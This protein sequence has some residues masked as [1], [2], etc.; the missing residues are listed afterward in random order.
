MKDDNQTPSSVGTFKSVSNAIDSCSSGGDARLMQQSKS[1]NAGCWLYDRCSH[2]DC[3]GFCLRRFKLSRLYDEAMVSD[4]QR[5]RIDL[6]V[7]RDLSDLDNFKYLST[8]EKNILGFVSHGGSLY[9]SSPI[10]GNGKTSWA[11]RLLQSY[12]DHIWPKSDLSCHGLFVHVPRLLIELKENISNPSDYARHVKENVI[13]ADLVVWDEIGTKGLTQFEHENI[14]NFVNAR[15]NAGKANIYTSN[16]SNDELREAVGDRLYSRIVIAS[17][18][19][20][21]RG[22]DKRALR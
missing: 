22:A 1:F 5:K 10:P 12:F 20:T 9:I 11:L 21:L 15:I 4:K 7:D 18:C 19:V 3:D 14:L 16:L 17:D 2:I 13:D 8:I 6:Y